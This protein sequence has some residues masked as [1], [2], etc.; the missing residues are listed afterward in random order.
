MPT[1][2]Q[3]KIF[4]LEQFTAVLA[5]IFDV[6]ESS[7]L[8]STDLSETIKDSIDLGELA[9]VLKS[10]YSVEPKDWELFK[11]NTTVIEVFNNFE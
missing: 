8:S 7:L 6:A 1:M 4:S 11:I 9:A 3:E 10:R 5:E 2:E